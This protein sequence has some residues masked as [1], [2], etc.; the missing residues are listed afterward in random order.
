MVN[1]ERSKIVLTDVIADE[2]AN[3]MIPKTIK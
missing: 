2:A 1:I 3:K